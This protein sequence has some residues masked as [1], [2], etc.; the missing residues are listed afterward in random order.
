MIS[1]QNEK[2]KL[3]NVNIKT[4]AQLSGVSIATV[5]NV[6]TGK[7]YV[8]PEVTQ[9]VLQTIKKVGYTPNQI[10]RSLKKKGT[11]FFGVMVPDVTN[12]FFAEIVRGIE[13]VALENGYQIF[14]CNTDGNVS[15]EKATLKSFI[16]HYVEGIINVAPR[17]EETALY[18]FIK[19]TPMV[20]VDRPISFHDSFFGLVYTDNLTASSKL[21]RHFIQ[22]GHTSFACL[23][24]PL[25][26]P[27]VRNRIAGFVGELQRLN[28]P[29]EK[30]IILH[31]E[32]KYESGFLLME[33]LF[34]L[35]NHP[36][37]I[38]ACNDLMAW[39]AIEAAKKKGFQIPKDLAIAGF[40]NVFFS[41][42]INP[43]L[44]TINQEKF[45]AGVIAT[46]MLL[47][48]N[49]WKKSASVIPDNFSRTTILQAD[50]IQR[51]ST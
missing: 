29:Q 35:K 34:T 19:R 21:A 5:S 10:A 17:M 1:Q 15:R 13:S 42:L 46:Q 8:S 41:E 18:T 7:K 40:D 6:I 12:P 47:K 45:N 28:I 4:V 23:A 43:S 2:E 20:V 51:K 50:L 49:T 22:K 37:A 16:E 48:I 24:G 39:G 27:N 3:K 26:V 33:K 31:G 44:T 11:T 9:R 25:I 14:L 32:F 38:F 30:I 36:T